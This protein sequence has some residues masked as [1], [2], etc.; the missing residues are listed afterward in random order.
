MKGS[1]KL[2][3]SL[4]K[5]RT[6]KENG[7]DLAEAKKILTA[8]VCSWTGPVKAVAWIIDE[9]EALQAKI[10]RLEAG[11]PNVDPEIVEI[12]NRMMLQDNLATKLPI[13]C[14]QQ[15]RRIYG[16]D[17]NHA[18]ET[19]RVD[20]DGDETQDED[21]DET[22]DEGEGTEIGYKD[23]WEFVT[24]CFTRKGCEDYIATNGH[25][26]REPR[27]YVESGHRNREWERLRDWLLGLATV[28]R[29]AGR[30]RRVG[31]IVREVLQNHLR[32]AGYSG[33]VNHGRRCVCL[34]QSFMSCCGREDQARWASTLPDCAVFPVD[35]PGH[36]SSLLE[37][38]FLPAL[39]FHLE[40]YGYGGL[41]SED[42]ECACLA[43][44]LAP[45][46]R[47]S[48]C[49]MDCFPGYKADCTCG[50]HGKWRVAPYRNSKCEE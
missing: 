14:V 43:A 29:P 41:Y 7:M 26:L 12:A 2:D 30:P 8:D 13:F 4:G 20:E 3:V 23:T 38:L 34:C 35:S 44:D 40:Y 19:C 36:A 50:L 31:E 16:L 15:K 1:M 25:N 45:C 22:Q 10:G 17:L 46:G 33:A 5:E 28:T 37:D 6:F 11:Y 32:R 47:H 49:V 48:E 42:G 24:A 9:C 27:I 39:R 18:D 21:G